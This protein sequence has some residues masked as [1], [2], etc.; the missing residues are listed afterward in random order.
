MT[1]AR[2]NIFDATLG[3]SGQQ[4][5]QRAALTERKSKAEEE[6]EMFREILSK[7]AEKRDGLE[8][9]S[10]ELRKLQEEIMRRKADEYRE[11]LRSKLR[12]DVWD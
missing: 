2:P 4:D 3:V 1:Q 8:K 6:A 10:A 7:R 11:R 12:P 5:L 9:K